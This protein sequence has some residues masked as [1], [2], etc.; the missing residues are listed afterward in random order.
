MSSLLEE[1]Q[2]QLK[3]AH[4]EHHREHYGFDCAIFQRQWDLPISL[5]L[6]QGNKKQAENTH[7]SAT[8]LFKMK[9]R[10]LKA[11]IH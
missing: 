10:S 4:T 5:L 3:K 6:W 7:I 8:E 11:Q 1:T 9:I 2:K